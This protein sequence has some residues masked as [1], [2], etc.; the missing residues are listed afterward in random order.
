M[1]KTNYLF[2]LLYFVGLIVTAY[3]LYQ[4]PML[5][6]ETQVVSLVQLKQAQSAIDQLYLVI[7]G[8]LTLG[9]IVIV[10]L[11]LTRQNTTEINA[12]VQRTERDDS[13]QEFEGS[14]DQN[15]QSTKQIEGLD[16]AIANGENEEA[17]FTKALSLVCRHIEASQAIAYQV[18]RSEE[19]S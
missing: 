13:L 7:G 2:T 11:W 9:T 17:T 6:V 16:E 14:Q 8:T 12:A 1:K 5:L 10:K 3:T 19:Y 15:Y 18:K 4:L